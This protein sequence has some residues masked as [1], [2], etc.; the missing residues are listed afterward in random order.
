MI[1]RLHSLECIVERT[2]D[3]EKFKASGYSGSAD[4]AVFYNVQKILNGRGYDLAKGTPG[5]HGH[6]TGEPYYLYPRRRSN[7][8]H[9][10]IHDS[11]YA[12]RCAAEDFNRFGV[13]TLNVEYDVNGKQPDCIDRVKALEEA[14]QVQWNHNSQTHS[15][16]LLAL[17]RYECFSDRRDGKKWDLEDMMDP[18]SWVGLGATSV[19]QAAVKAGVM[20]HAISHDGSS[21]GPEKGVS[22]WW[23]FTPKGAR[24]ALAWHWAGHNCGDGHQLKS[25]PSHKGVGYLPVDVIG[26]SNWQME[27]PA[28]T[29]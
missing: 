17:R 28:A 21:A 29:V 13:V 20:R 19:Y 10:Y 6:L 18:T 27:R 24:I 16:M 9:I 5:N 14:A 8:P 12:V 25:T 2:N 15:A 23:A 7:G 11:N 1:V 26:K 22:G 3:R 4:S